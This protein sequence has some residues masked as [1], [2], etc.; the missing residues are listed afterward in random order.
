MQRTACYCSSSNQISY[1][2]AVTGSLETNWP[3][4]AVYVGHTGF[5]SQIAISLPS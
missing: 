5:M 2:W 4:A 3:F 1:I